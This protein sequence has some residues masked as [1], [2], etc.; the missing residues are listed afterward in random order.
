MWFLTLTL[1]GLLL[2]SPE[3]F[4]SEEACKLAVT[5]A[6]FGTCE[7]VPEPV[8]SPDSTE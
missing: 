2:V 1:N 6:H 3:P 8:A 7:H 5:Q 4:H